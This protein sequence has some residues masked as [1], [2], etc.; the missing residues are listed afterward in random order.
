MFIKTSYKAFKEIQRKKEYHMK[1]TRQGGNTFN[2]CCN[3]GM[4]NDPKHLLSLF[5]QWAVF[6]FLLVFCTCFFLFI[7]APVLSQLP[8]IHILVLKKSRLKNEV[9]Q[10]SKIP[11]V[12]LIGNYEAMIS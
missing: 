3:N 1:W 6:T 8:V 12:N 9:L 4:H 10:Y 7:I 11:P 5:I 2:Y